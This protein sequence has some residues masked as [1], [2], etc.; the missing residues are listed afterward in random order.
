VAAGAAIPIQNA[1]EGNRTF[2]LCLLAFAF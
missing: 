2:D 1:A